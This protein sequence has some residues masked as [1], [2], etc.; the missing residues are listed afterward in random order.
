[1][2]DKIS[3]ESANVKLA[4]GLARRAVMTDTLLRRQTIAPALFGKHYQPL[5]NM[6]AALQA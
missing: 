6:A 4:E 3:I 1:V 2:L 5:N